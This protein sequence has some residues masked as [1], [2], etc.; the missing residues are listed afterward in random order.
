M[1]YTY[2]E[3]A[4]AVFLYLVDAIARGQACRG[5]MVPLEIRGAS[6]SVSLDDAGHA[7][8]IEF[9]GVSELFTPKAIE[10]IRA[11]RS[12]FGQSERP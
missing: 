11:G 8:G 7:L 1:R 9:L 10:A 5:A 3:D 12:T 2:D 4:D 6:I